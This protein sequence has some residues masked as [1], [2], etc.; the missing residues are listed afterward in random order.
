MAEDT[1]DQGVT[2]SRDLLVKY[3]EQ[4]TGN[5]KFPGDGNRSKFIPPLH[6]YSAEQFRKIRTHISL[7]NPPCRTV[8]ITST[9]P[10]EGKSLIAMNLALAFAQEKQNKTILLDADLRMPSI[11]P[12]FSIGGL[13]DYLEGRAS[14]EEILV[15]FEAQNLMVV[16]SGSPS[17]R[18]SELIGSP[19]MKELLG[20]LREIQGDTYIVIDSPPILVSSEPTLLSKLV[21]GI[22]LVV[23]ADWTPKRSVRKGINSI[24]QEKILGIIFNQMNLRP[25]KYYSKYH[26][27]YYH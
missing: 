2:P 13:S 6:S 15:Y 9:F 5:L 23:M 18:A 11:Y 25:S 26:Y 1:M 4:R 17:Q 20:N 27:G 22:L 14:L 16:P 24:V 21:D 7:Q 3:S 12:D 10:Q 8:L 19:R